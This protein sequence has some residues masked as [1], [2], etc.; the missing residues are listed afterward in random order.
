MNSDME[1]NINDMV[2]IL[3]ANLKE[4]TGVELN[5]MRKGKIMSECFWACSK[6]KLS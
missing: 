3:A 5:S 6:S 2:E 4:L 1:G